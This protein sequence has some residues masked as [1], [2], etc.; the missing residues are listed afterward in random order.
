MPIP[1]SRTNENAQII[2]DR[3]KCNL[4]DLCIKICK[5]FSLKIENGKLVVNNEPI[6]GCFGCGQCATICPNGAIKILGREF[7]P[8]DIIDL[9]SKDKCSTYEQLHSLMLRRRSVRDFKDKSVESEIVD[10]I[11]RSC[12]TAPM[13]IPPSDVSLL[14]LQGKDKV[15][16]FTEDFLSYVKKMKWMFPVMTTLFRPFF[17][18][19]EI[20]QF[21]EFVIPLYNKLI[22]KWEEGE[23]FLLYSAPLVIYFYGNPYADPVDSYIPATYSMLVAESLGLGSC[24]IGSIAPMIKK[25]GVQLKKKYGIDLKSKDGIFVIYGY[26]KYKYHKAIKRTFA[27]VNYA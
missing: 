8:E 14:I 17:S 22:E 27:K 13:G 25:G 23:D 9:P 11:I 26:P 6:F 18:N 7:H 5:D 2:I 19:I 12:S 21:K 16:E 4:C 15:R 20:V 24:M 1:T 10:K 3:E